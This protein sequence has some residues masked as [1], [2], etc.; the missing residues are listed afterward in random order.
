[1][2]SRTVMKPVV[3]KTKC[4][5]CNGKELT[6]CVGV[7]PMSLFVIKNGKSTVKP[8]AIKD[9]LGCKACEASCPTKAI[10]VKE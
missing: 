9:C 6:E 8:S 5:G 2:H 7:C 4:N 1:M 3:D 10:I